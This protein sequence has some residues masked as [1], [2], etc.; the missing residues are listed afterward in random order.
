MGLLYK[1]ASS[2]STSSQLDNGRQGASSLLNFCDRCHRPSKYSGHARK[3]QASPF[4]LKQNLTSYL[5]TNDD[6][7]PSKQLT[8]TKMLRQP[9][10]LL[11]PPLLLLLMMIL[12]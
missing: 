5:E 12:H 7:K 1:V 9:L 4:Y 6:T 10:L 2:L 8:T 11:L 3:K